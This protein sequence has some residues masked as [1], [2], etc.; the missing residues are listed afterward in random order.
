MPLKTSLFQRFFSDELPGDIACFLAIYDAATPELRMIN[1]AIFF[2]CYD[3]RLADHGLVEQ[4]DELLDPGPEL[5]WKLK[6]RALSTA[7]KDIIAPI[8]LGNKLLSTLPHQFSLIDG[9]ALTPAWLVFF[10]RCHPDL[11]DLSDLP[12]SAIRFIGIVKRFYQDPPE[13]HLQLVDR[14]KMQCRAFVIFD[15]VGFSHLLMSKSRVTDYCWGGLAKAATLCRP[16]AR[17]QA[18]YLGS[19]ACC[20][21]TA[22]H[23]YYKHH[24]DPMNPATLLPERAFTSDAEVIRFEGMVKRKQTQ[25]RPNRL[26]RTVSVSSD[27]TTGESKS[28]EFEIV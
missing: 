18:E 20:C 17:E 10:L 3:L 1:A 21:T 16:L 26:V 15:E 7:L 9:T 8:C 2:K 24:F 28:S 23:Q 5:Q 11:S 13:L 14:L 22:V 19:I 25:F 27:D 4:V 12:M 6:L